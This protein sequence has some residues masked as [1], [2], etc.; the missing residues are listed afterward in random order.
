VKDELLSVQAAAAELGVSPRRVQ[1]LIQDGR[2]PAE[3]L[4]GSNVLIIRAKDLE[5]VR[6][7]PTGRPKKGAK[8]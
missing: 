8:R 5:R 1:K 4:K 2:L 6:V 3:T 7:R